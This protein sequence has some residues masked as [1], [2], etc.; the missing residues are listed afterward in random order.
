MHLASTGWTPSCRRPHAVLAN[1]HQH[2]ATLLTCPPKHSQF[3]QSIQPPSL[4]LSHHGRGPAAA[5]QGGCFLKGRTAGFGS[6]QRRLCHS[7][8]C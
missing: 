6:S 5:Q 7:S 3:S 8:L 4:S 1:K 2:P